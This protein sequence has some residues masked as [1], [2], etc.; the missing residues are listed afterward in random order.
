MI[1]PAVSLVL[2]TGNNG[3]VG[4]ADAL[5]WNIPDELRH[6]RELTLNHTVIM[7]RKTFESIGLPLPKRHNI[8]ISKRLGYLPG[9]KVA[10]SLDAALE[11]AEP[12]R[13]VFIIGGPGLWLE[14][15]AFADKA[16]ISLIDYDGPAD[17]SIDPVFFSEVRER[18]RLDEV[19]AKPGFTITKW[20]N[21]AS[22]RIAT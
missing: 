3:Q 7:G 2:A 15:L 5:P 16:Y 21:P 19:L 18:F 11:M 17:A 14:G 4:L 12:S 20:V 8:V 10:D 6:F 9:A 1:R 22:T 13:M